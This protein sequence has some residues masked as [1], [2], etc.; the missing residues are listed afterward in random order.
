METLARPR[1]ALR[2]VAGF[3]RRLWLVQTLM[4]PVLVLSG[5]TVLAAVALW[6]R[7]RTTS[8]G[9]H[10]LPETPG[11]HRADTEDTAGDT[12]LTLPQ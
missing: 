5:V 4:W 3:Q 10:E 2:R 6:W 12:H 9:R 7:S 11:A 8:D 1:N